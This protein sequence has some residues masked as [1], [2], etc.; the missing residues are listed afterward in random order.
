MFLL[1]NEKKIKNQN[2]KITSLVGLTEMKN[3]VFGLAHMKSAVCGNLLLQIQ[4][5]ENDIRRSCS[6]LGTHSA[7]LLKIL[8][9]ISLKKN[10]KL[11]YKNNASLVGLTGMKNAVLV[12]PT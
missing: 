5:L 7:G 2:T 11:E 1:S 3:A 8:V 9:K 10:R 12:W 4:R 6:W